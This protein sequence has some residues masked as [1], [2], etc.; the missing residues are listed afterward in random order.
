M[1]KMHTNFAVTDD[2]DTP[3]KLSLQSVWHYAKLLLDLETEIS[4]SFHKH[5]I[6][7]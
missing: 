2:A 1:F 5:F 4:D 7:A 6:N 3:Y